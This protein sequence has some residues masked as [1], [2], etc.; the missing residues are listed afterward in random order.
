MP[1]NWNLTEIREPIPPQ[2]AGWLAAAGVAVG[3][4]TYAVVSYGGLIDPRFAPTFGRI[5]T[6]GWEIQQAG[7]LTTDL[8]ASLVRVMAGLFLGSTAAIFLGLLMGTFAVVD[9]FF[10]KALSALR[11]VP[12]VA[13]MP[14]IIVTAGIG[15]F[16]KIFIIFLAVFL[17]V[18]PKSIEAVRAVPER[19]IH[20]VYT[21]GASKASVIVHLIVRKAAPDLLRAVRSSS[22]LAWTYVMVA[23]LINSSEGLGF[24]IVKAQRFLQIDR[25]IFLVIVIG[26]LGVLFD[27]TL[28]KINHKMF[29]WDEINQAEMKKR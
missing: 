25:I 21:L 19:L 24:R 3:L 29:P 6:A 4:L 15:E 11:F 10:S 17:D 28:K 2:P 27:F 12:P 13:L 14:L 23:E 20:D 26:I 16:S 5:F 18:A 7:E 9:A 22:G 8:K 1:K